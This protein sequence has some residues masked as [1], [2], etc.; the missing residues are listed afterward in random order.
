MNST[1]EAARGPH[2]DARAARTALRR[3]AGSR[4]SAPAGDA[5][6]RE[7]GDDAR[8]PGHR[9][10][11]EGDLRDRVGLGGLATEPV[12]APERLVVDDER[13]RLGAGDGTAVQRGPV[14]GERGIEGDL[15]GERGRHGHDGVRR[16]DDEAVG[17]D[18]DTVL[19]LVDGPD[20]RAEVHGVA[21]GVGHAP[22]DRA[23]APLDQVLL[24]PVLDREQRVEAA[25][26]AHEEQQVQERR[27][28]ERAREQPAHR[29]LEQVARRRRPDAR[30]L[31]EPGDRSSIPLGRLRRFP[32]R[33]ERDVLAHAVD[34]RLGQRDREH[35][36]RADLRYEA[37]V[38][39][40]LPAGDEQVRTLDPRLVGRHAE[41]A[42]EPEDGVVP[43]AE[44]PAAPIDRAAVG[45]VEG[46]DATADAVA[47]LEHH[48]GLAGLAEPEGRRQP[49]VAGAHD[50]HVRLDARRHRRGTVLGLR[51]RVAGATS[52][53]R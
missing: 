20:R 4:A 31:E 9:A 24:R 16:R 14:V 29:G 46:P 3:S 51:R 38:A 12:G 33:L 28:V 50:A 40:R 26:P 35:G 18:D 44:P 19:V 1:G 43:R 36:E 42:R 30:S 32:R 17:F 53:R 25:V 47:G 37:R 5:P 7:R 23:G 34:L 6:E 2:R 39:T 52:G 49:R 41:F 11:V 13:L 48:D 21:E 27:L 8:A 45:Q 15:E 22:G 10:G